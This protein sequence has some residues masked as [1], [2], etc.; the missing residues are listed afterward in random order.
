MT[1]AQI[2]TVRR[3]LIENARLRSDIERI[4]CELAQMR[5]ANAEL[6]GR[7]SAIQEGG[8]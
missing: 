2:V 5:E 4:G 1:N 8:K 7:L 6:Q 3:L